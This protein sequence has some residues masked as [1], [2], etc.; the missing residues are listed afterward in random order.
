MPGGQVGQGVG[1]CLDVV[2]TVTTN[3]LTSKLFVG[4]MQMKKNLAGMSGKVGERV[5][6]FMPTVRLIVLS[7]LKKLN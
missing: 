6:F 5:A 2:A 1:P 7:N 4:Y 3:D